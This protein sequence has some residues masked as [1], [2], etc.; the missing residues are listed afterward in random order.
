MSREG[1]SRVHFHIKVVRI[2]SFQR[3]LHGNRVL[4]VG[5][6]FNPNG[7]QNKTKTNDRFNVNQSYILCKILSF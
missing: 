6:R 1:E 3:T 2:G 7:H 4:F 5:C